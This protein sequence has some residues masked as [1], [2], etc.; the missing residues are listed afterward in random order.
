MKEKIIIA[1]LLCA[2]AFM[3]V[4][5]C[6]RNNEYYMSSSEVDAII[7]GISSR[8]PSGSHSVVSDHVNSDH[9]DEI[10][11]SKP[12]NSSEKPDSSSS[13]KPPQTGSTDSKVSSTTPESSSKVSS[14]TPE[15]S[16]KVSSSSE[17]E[18]SSDAAVPPT[19]GDDGEDQIEDN[20]IQIGPPAGVLPPV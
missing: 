20:Y 13:K 1:V 7:N 5:G 17:T 16:S 3:F 8:R 10:E 14:T 6:K 11:T 12:Q 4:T 19:D 2:I 9:E 18:T 15:S